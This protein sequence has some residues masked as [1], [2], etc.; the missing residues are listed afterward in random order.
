[1]PIE[2]AA[3][4]GFADQAHLMRLSVRWLRTTP[5]VRRRQGGAAP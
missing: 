5:P 4:R 2:V 3:A 1:M